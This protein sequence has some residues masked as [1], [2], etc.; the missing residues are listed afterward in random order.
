MA[1]TQIGQVAGSCLLTGTK[2][3]QQSHTC[4]RAIRSPARSHDCWS[5]RQ[6][7]RNHY[8]N[9]GNVGHQFPETTSP[10]HHLLLL[11]L[12]CPNSSSQLSH[13]LRCDTP[14]Y[15]RK[16]NTTQSVCYLFRLSKIN[17]ALLWPVWQKGRSDTNKKFI[18]RG[19]RGWGERQHTQAY[20]WQAAGTFKLIAQNKTL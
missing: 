16:E 19:F 18:W 3:V 4:Q 7:G 5:P 8:W 10:G 1:Q 11:V 6:Q 12:I 14:R 2:F 13:T 15:K 17:R 20:P 9:G